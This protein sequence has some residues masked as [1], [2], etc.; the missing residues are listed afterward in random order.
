M[1][2]AAARLGAEIAAQLAAIG[3][4]AHQVQLVVQVLVEFGHDFARLQAAPIGAQALDDARHDLQERQVFFDDAQH[5]RAQHLHGAFAAVVQYGEVHLG[6]RG[7]GHRVHLELREQLLGRRAQRGFDAGGGLRGRERRHP[8][9]QQGQ[10]V[11]DV[12]GDQVAAGGQHLPELHEN[13]AQRFERQAQALP[14]RLA[15][16]GWRAPAR[17]DRSAAKP[18]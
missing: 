18:G 17:P 15:R 14:A 2:V 4:F 3:G 8:V 11:G 12:G 13:G 9:L 16:P 5:A 1:H 6:D 10:L 7:R